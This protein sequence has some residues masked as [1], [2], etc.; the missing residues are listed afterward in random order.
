MCF[1][2]KTKC[3]FCGVEITQTGKGRTRDYCSTNCQELNKFKS[4]FEDR[5][6][7]VEYMTPDAIRD[8]RSSMFQLSNLTNTKKVQQ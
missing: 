1:G 3:N 5:L 2:T 4:A 6:L 7:K 8:F